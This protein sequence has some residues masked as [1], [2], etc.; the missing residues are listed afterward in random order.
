MDKSQEKPSINILK[1][2]PLGFRPDPE[3]LVQVIREGIPV[4]GSMEIVHLI[5]DSGIQKAFQS[6]RDK[7]LLKGMNS[8]LILAGP[9]DLTGDTRAITK[10]VEVIAKKT[11]MEAVVEETTTNLADENL[12]IIGY[13]V[14]AGFRQDALSILVDKQLGLEIYSCWGDLLDRGQPLQSQ[15]EK[16]KI[17]ANVSFWTLGKGGDLKQI[18]PN[19]VTPI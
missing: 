15:L 1:R 2:E 13:G 4:R 19:N 5:I 18:E 17:A 16:P 12:R 14:V 6:M 10:A 3:P 9:K 7:T 11:E 8:I